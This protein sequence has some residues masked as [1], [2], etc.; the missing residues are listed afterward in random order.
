MK[1]AL[2][3]VVIT[4]LA[5]CAMVGPDY[6]RPAIDLPVAYGEADVAPGA[7]AGP[8]P[9]WWTL[10]RDPRLTDL[11]TVGF[12]NNTD[13]KVAA[14][15]IE[16]AEAALREANAVL[17]P[18]V[19]GSAGVGRSRTSTRTGTQTSSVGPVRNNFAL[20]ATTSF[21]LDF[22]GRL[23]R[24]AEAA[25]AQY[26]ASRYGQDVVTLTLASAIA[27][28][29]F[30]A[31]SFDAQVIVSQETLRAAEES[32]DLAGKRFQAGLISELDVNQAAASRAQLAAQV[33]DLRRQ[34]AATVH[35]LGVLVG[36]PGLA[37]EPGDMR[38][39]PAPPLPP[40]GLP[41]TLLE[42][43]P[44]I[45]QAE[46][47]LAAAT[48]LI[49]VARAAQLPTI[50]LTGSAGVQSRELDTLFSSGAGLW[51]IGLNA[52]GPIFDAGR[53]AARTDQAEAR[54]RQAAALYEK[55]ARGAFRE[56]SDALSN[57]EFSSAAEVELQE[58][59]EQSRNSL[60]LATLRY[61]SGYSAYLEVLDAQRT[62]NDAQLAYLRNRQ[63]FL[64]YTV[65]LM[66]ALGGG[67][68]P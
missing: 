50:S 31:R 56:V 68:R 52:L 30:A 57:I 22:W 49:G 11:M 8:P 33:S 13:L 38:A 28:T 54:A 53:Y 41:S 10:Y 66:N 39:V 29:Y 35:Q 65:D 12:R 45:R 63:G 17:T 36:V 61:E 64:S 20:T 47:Q 15:R 1:R 46:A 60:K 62:L 37:L 23:R 4:A 55:A 7:T 26:V 48:A 25:R 42:R 44:D 18:S 6:R 5:G 16:E 43:R 27:Q 14:A 24:A 3:L 19:D 40:A 2:A 51:S 32:L 58:R 34:R 9:D 59:V 21:E 67:W